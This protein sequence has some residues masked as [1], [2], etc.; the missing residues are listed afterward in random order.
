MS[1]YAAERKI[2]THTAELAGKSL[3]RDFARRSTLPISEKGPSDFVSSADLAAQA[4]ICAE[5]SAA[6][7]R[8][9]FLLEEETTPQ[10]AKPGESAAKL[11]PIGRHAAEKGDPAHA[12]EAT[13]SVEAAHAAQ[14]CF[15]V[16]PLDGTT[17][18]LHGIPHFAVSIA[19]E[20]EGQVVAGVVLNPATSETFWAAKGEGAWLGDRRLTVSAPKKTAHAI[21]G[22]GIPH[23]GRPAHARFLTS[24][25]RIMP[26]VAGIRR[27]GCA[28]LDL[29]YVAAG[30][31]D[32]FWEVGLSAW[33]IAAGQ[34]LVT[35]AGGI[36][37]GCGGEPL[38]LDGPDILATSGE[39][40]HRTA[41]RWVAAITNPNGEA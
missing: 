13:H 20:V 36:V 1:P 14:G 5:L 18:F 25:A 4:V 33:D 37:T 8:H 40:L 32:M 6:F 39:A 12:V 41:M 17:N 10:E 11:A 24:L 35:E 3:M 9:R 38:R 34:L 23:L 26:E 2:L 21:V 31:F 27:L 22:T 19:L 16:D 29:A 15:I 30:R 28:A 7:P